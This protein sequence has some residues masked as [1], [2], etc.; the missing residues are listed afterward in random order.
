MGILE[1]LIEASLRQRILVIVGVL[2]LVGFGTGS[3]L[4]IPID[5]FPDVTNIQ[6]E[7]LSTAPGMSPPGSGALC[8]V[9]GRGGDARTAAAQPGPLGIQFGALG[10]HRHIRGWRR[11]LFCPPAGSRSA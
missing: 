7:V 9:P 5:A 1:R 10:G 6:I 4:H 2:F 8:H 3:V 11:H